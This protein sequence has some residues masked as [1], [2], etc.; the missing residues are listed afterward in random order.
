MK[1]K[2]TTNA[3]FSPLTLGLTIG[4]ALLLLV[5]VLLICRPT[6]EVYQ[7]R[8][9]KTVMGVTTYE[10]WFTD[11]MSMLEFIFPPIPYIISL[12]ALSNKKKNV[13][14]KLFNGEC[15]KSPNFFLIIATAIINLGLFTSYYSD[16]LDA[17]A[18][19]TE[20]GAYCRLTGWGQGF[21]VCTIILLVV[22][23]ILS[24]MAKIVF[25]KKSKET[26]LEPVE[27]MQDSQ[28]E[29]D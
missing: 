26:P 7:P 25:M 24:I 16:T 1:Q 5:N 29:D 19:Y 21:V 18:R 9:S 27:G 28:K 12:I 10:G 2:N 17:A 20:H 15:K 23:V 11:T 3:T 8:Y 13:F 4:L 22:A 6:I 14:I